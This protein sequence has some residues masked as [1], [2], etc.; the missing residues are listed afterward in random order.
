[1]VSG[2]AAIVMVANELQDKKL[3]FERVEAM[4]QSAHEEYLLA[5]SRLAVVAIALAVAYF[6][7]IFP[8]PIS[9]H[10]ELRQDLSST[11]YFLS[12]YYSMISQTVTARARGQETISNRNENRLAK[13]R[14]KTFT[15]LQFLFARLRTHVTFTKWQFIIGGRFPKAQYVEMIALCEEI[16]TATAVMGYASVSFMRAMEGV[17]NDRKGPDTWLASF[18]KLLYTLETING[19]V[20]SSLVMLSNHMASG[21][22]FPPY[23]K[24]PNEFMLV[25]AMEEFDRNMLAITNLME[26]G[27]AG[28]VTMSMAGRGIKRAIRRMIE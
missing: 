3:G 2:L 14:T 20:T 15:K 24:A 13:A 18:R 12:S 19:E 16:C 25:K 27:Y 10:S 1:M 21:S 4:G 8:F 23:V 5:P 7:T 22:P 6:W 17:Q 26:P 11:I 28:F 9:E